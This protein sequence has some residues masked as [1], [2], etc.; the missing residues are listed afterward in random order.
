MNYYSG[1]F[2][3]GMDENEFRDGLEISFANGA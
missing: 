2:V 1:F 3:P